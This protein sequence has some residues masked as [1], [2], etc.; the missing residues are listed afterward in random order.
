VPAVAA[1][2]RRNG[3]ALQLAARKAF[4]IFATRIGSHTAVRFACAFLQESGKT[5]IESRF[6]G[7]HL[8]GLGVR[9]WVGQAQFD[10]YQLF[11]LMLGVK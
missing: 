3:L 7:I 8:R 1:M 2:L 5:G 4:F 9:P 10:F 11:S 6:S